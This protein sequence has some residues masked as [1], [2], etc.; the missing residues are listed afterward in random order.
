[1]CSPRRRWQARAWRARTWTVFSLLVV[2]PKSPLLRTVLSERLG[3]PVDFSADPMTVVGRGAAVYASTLERAIKPN[4]PPVGCVP[5]KLAY[6]PVSAELR[7]TVAGR[8]TDT[9][10]DVEIKLEAE[11][12]L[13]TSG[14]IRPKGG[15]FETPVALK[16]GDISSFWVYARD[17]QGRLIDTDPAEIQSPA[18]ARSVGTPAPPHALY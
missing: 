8:V 18:R 5:L 2:R 4:C 10:R 9:T 17:G 6:E 16:E 3:A 1:M 13:W 12:G 15:F 14:W 11:G 7:C